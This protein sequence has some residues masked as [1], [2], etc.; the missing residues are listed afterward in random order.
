VL[1]VR[2]SQSWDG[3]MVCERR[4]LGQIFPAIA[5]E[6]VHKVRDNPRSGRPSMLRACT[7]PRMDASSDRRAHVDGHVPGDS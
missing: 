3:H 7:G 5:E 2:V 4:S 6:Y 1:R